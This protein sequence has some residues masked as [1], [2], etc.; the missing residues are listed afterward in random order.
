MRWT[1]K[2]CTY[3]TKNRKRIIEHY[4]D[5]HGHHGRNCPL[6]CI[7]SDCPQLFRS[8][9]SLKKHLKEHGLA[10]HG[11]LGGLN[12]QIKCQLCDFNDPVT[13]KQ[14]FG[15]LAKH[16]RNKET[17]TCPFNQCSYKTRNYTTFVKRGKSGNVLF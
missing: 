1:C 16:L 5:I 3:F 8:Q 6:P 9:E 15:Y 2:F 12:L 4:R 7:Y 14:Y 13:I 10:R 11:P 17:V